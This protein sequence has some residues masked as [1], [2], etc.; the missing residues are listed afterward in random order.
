M[1]KLIAAILFL[2]SAFAC[3]E[4]PKPNPNDYTIA[5]HVQSSRQISQCT[6]NGL[7]EPEQQLDVT[8]NGKKYELQSAIAVD[9]LRV[10]DY[11]AKIAKDQTRHAYEYTRVYEFLFP[12]GSTRLYSV[13]GESE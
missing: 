2:T 1:K 10:G 5:I 4:K 9:L 13:I 11:K 7:C 6:G 8:M 3:A 12:D